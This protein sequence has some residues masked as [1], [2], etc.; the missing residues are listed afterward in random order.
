MSARARLL[1]LHLAAGAAL[2]AVV[3][4]GCEDPLAKLNQAKQAVAEHSA[5]SGGGSTGAADFGDDQAAKERAG[6][7]SLGPEH[8]SKR[9]FYQ[10]VDG[11]GRV[12]FVERLA[13]VPEQW[14]ARPLPSTN[15]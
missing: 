12:R 7:T 5:S 14:R 10:F 2:L 6:G 1:S 3:A 13:D 15:W 4:L 11:K 8:V 9:L